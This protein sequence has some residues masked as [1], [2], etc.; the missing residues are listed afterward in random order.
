MCG[1]VVSCEPR[2][3]VLGYIH[4]PVW[5]DS[6]NH[7]V[8]TFWQSDIENHA[9]D[10]FGHAWH[11][12][13]LNRKINVYVFIDDWYVCVILWKG[14]EPTT[15]RIWG[16]EFEV[17]LSSVVICALQQTK[18]QWMPYNRGRL[19]FRFRRLICTNHASKILQT[20]FAIFVHVRRFNQYFHVFLGDGTKP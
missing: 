1:W 18:A 2:N 19:L 8:L 20:D 15:G 16:V 14:N 12:N 17:L 13:R 9:Q 11:T 3:D 7:T 10:I 6:Y 4:V 5:R